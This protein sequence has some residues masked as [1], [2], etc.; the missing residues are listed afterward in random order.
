M[1][2]N[3]PQFK[4]KVLQI[5]KDNDKSGAFT[6]RKLTD[7]PTD[8]LS[9]V[10]RRYVTLNGATSGRPRGSVLGQSYFDTSIGKPV[11]WD[12]TRFVDATGSTA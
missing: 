9:V 3:S 11:W 4:E 10:N 12:G 6:D 2:F 7:T 5:I 1:D 8:A